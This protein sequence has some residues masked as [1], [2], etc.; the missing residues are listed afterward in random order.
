MNFSEI[1]DELFEKEKLLEIK[2]LNG[3]SRS[4][5]YYIKNDNKS[6]LLRLYDALDAG[7]F[8]QTIEWYDYLTNNGIKTNTIISYGECKT[9]NFL[10]IK[11]TW[12]EGETL[13]E[14][15][16]ISDKNAQRILG[17]KARNLLKNIHNT[18]I[19]LHLSKTN[20]FD[21]I[22]LCLSKAKDIYEIKKYPLLIEYVNFLK[23]DF[24]QK[25]IN[26]K[27]TLLHG[28][29][30]PENVIVSDGSL[31][32]IDWEPYSF[33]NPIW[34]FVR[35]FTIAEEYPIYFSS[36]LD[37]YFNCDIPETFWNELLIYSVMHQINLIHLQRVNRNFD[38]VFIRKQ[39]EIVFKQY[40][41]LKTNIPLFYL[42]RE[43]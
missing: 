33:G 22:K 21:D 6:Y 41:E 12:I 43:R 29:F 8:Y 36:L 16:K 10:Y 34:D 28:D 7:L 40:D 24:S 23:Q 11:F 32:A 30:H 26:N 37:S 1:I 2:K 15:L 25:F 19:S 17:Y 27:H 20:A 18:R 14:I 9:A 42:K 3:Y 31:S 4:E 39:H 5:N 13:S 38:D 35:L